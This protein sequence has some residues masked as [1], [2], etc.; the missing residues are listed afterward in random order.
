M[1]TWLIPLLYVQLQSFVLDI[2]RIFNEF[3]NEAGDTFKSV[4]SY[5][6]Q[7]LLQYNPD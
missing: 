4:R 6:E 1:F 2:P 5:M 7:V 3:L